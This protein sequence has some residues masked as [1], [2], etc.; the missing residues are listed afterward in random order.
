VDTSA[1]HASERQRL[2]DLV[3]HVP[4]ESVGL[5][6]EL[7]SRFSETR[8]G[9]P[10]PFD[11][12]PL[13]SCPQLIRVSRYV[14][15]NY[16]SEISVARAA[17]EAGLERKYFSTFFRKKVGICFRNWVMFVRVGRARQLLAERERTISQIAFDTGFQDLRTFERAF[18]KCTGVSA[19]ALRKRDS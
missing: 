16:A 4:D 12:A 7:L 11:E 14:R 19:A 13:E 9:T 17:Q 6:V 8:N 5:V 2:H 18:H 10:S 15:A 3:E 1:N